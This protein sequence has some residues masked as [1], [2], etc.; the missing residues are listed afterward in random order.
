MQV[1]GLSGQRPQSVTWISLAIIR[2]CHSPGRD[3]PFGGRGPEHTGREQGP[4][5]ASAHPTGIPPIGSAGR[6]GCEAVFFR[7]AIIRLI[8]CHRGEGIS[9]VRL[10]SIQHRAPIIEAR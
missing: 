2:S 8:L 5:T 4:D 9:V 3:M 6:I 7:S 10:S 1:W